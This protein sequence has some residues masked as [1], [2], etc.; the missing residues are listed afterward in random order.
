MYVYYNLMEAS[1]TKEIKSTDGTCNR[2]G[3]IS[4]A[5]LYSL[6]PYLDNILLIFNLFY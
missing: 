2:R 3:L 6:S 1:N 5:S 4:F